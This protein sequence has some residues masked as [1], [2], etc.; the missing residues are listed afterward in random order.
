M[1]R[2]CDA[3][4][5]EELPPPGWGPAVCMSMGNPQCV[6]LAPAGTSLADVDLRRIAAPVEAHPL[7]PERANVMLAAVDR[8]AAGTMPVLQV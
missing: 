8:G 3:R 6:L 5:V 4:A 1:A 2:A 7:F